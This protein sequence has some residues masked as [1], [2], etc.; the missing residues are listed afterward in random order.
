MVVVGLAEFFDQQAHRPADYALDA[1]ALDLDRRGRVE[2][3]ESPGAFPSRPRHVVIRRLVA[4]MRATEP[5]R[6][7]R[8]RN[9]PRLVVALRRCIPDHAAAQPGRLVLVQRERDRVNRAASRTLGAPLLL[10]ALPKARVLDVAGLGVHDWRLRGVVDFAAPDF[11][12]ATDAG[13]GVTVWLL[14]FR[15]PYLVIYF[16]PDGLR[17]LAR[18][19]RRVEQKKESAEINLGRRPVRS[20]SRQHRRHRLA[21]FE[22]RVKPALGVPVNHLVGLH[23]PRNR[24]GVVGY[25][26]RH[27]NIR[28]ERAADLHG[29]SEMHA[30]H[31]RILERIEDRNQPRTQSHV[32]RSRRR[33]AFRQ[34]DVLARP[35][36][37][38]RAV[39]PREAE[40]CEECVGFGHGFIAAR[41]A[42]RSASARSA[43]ATAASR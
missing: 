4:A 12:E 29:F 28:D 35:L 17:L 15:Q 22:D 32:E 2:R 43:R 37:N 31:Q 7:D 13:D 27:P 18:N 3:H 30:A 24:S 36:V 5:A 25:Q 20:R 42:S 9:V 33:V 11:L 10:I 16:E 41:S 39:R 14:P 23:R 8:P 6:L 26:P 34:H 38:R 1:K 19:V 40:V 21:R